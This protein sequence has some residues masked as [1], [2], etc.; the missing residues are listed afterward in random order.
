MINQRKGHTGL[1]LKKSTASISLGKE[2]IICIK[3][4]RLSIII[5]Q[6]QSTKW[7]LKEKLPEMKEEE[8]K[9][10]AKRKKRRK[11]TQRLNLILFILFGDQ[12]SIEWSPISLPPFFLLFQSIMSLFWGGFPPISIAFCFPIL[13]VSLSRGGKCCRNVGNWRCTA[14]HFMLQIVECDWW[15][16]LNEFSIYGYKY[17]ILTS[18]YVTYKD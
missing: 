18:Y 5:T 11:W 1:G 14:L 16:L 12:Y 2:G 15:W 3:H 10:V 6:K 13:E 8:A 4:W 7:Q 17:F 9:H